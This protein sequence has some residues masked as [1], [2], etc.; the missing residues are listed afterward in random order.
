MKCKKVN[1]A[2]KYHEGQMRGMND[3]RK[4]DFMDCVYVTIGLSVS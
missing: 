1:Q 4:Y 2:G 3:Y